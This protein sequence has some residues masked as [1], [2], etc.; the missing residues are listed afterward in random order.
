MLTIEIK[1]YNYDFKMLLNYCYISES[2]LINY[3]QNYIT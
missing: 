2:I 1:N 3:Q